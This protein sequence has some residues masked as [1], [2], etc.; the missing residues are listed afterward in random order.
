MK[1]EPTSA[2]KKFERMRNVSKD[3]NGFYE[4]NKPGIR[5][6]R[7]I[8]YLTKVLKLRISVIGE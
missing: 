8:D 7:L 2:M 6:W 1:Y 4:V 5:A 3:K